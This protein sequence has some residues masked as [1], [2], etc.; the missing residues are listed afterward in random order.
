MKC[1]S[2][3]YLILFFLTVSVAHSA[4]K[5]QSLFANT[6]SES[7]I[8]AVIDNSNKFL[9]QRNKEWTDSKRCLCCHTTLPYMLARGLDMNSAEN[10]KKLKTSA[11]M[12]VEN[13]DLAPWYLHDQTG[14]NSNPTESVLNAMTLVMHDQARKT[15]LQAVTLK[16]IDR[17]FEQIGDDGKLHWLDFGLEPFESKN[18]ELWGNAFAILTIEMAQKKSK[19]KAPELKYQNLKHSL[20]SEPSKLNL[21]EKSI[22]LWAHSISKNVLTPQLARQFVAELK[23]VQ[24][25]NGSWNQA[26]ILKLGQD[27]ED[28][29]STAIALLAMAKM[30]SKTVSMDRAAEWLISKQQTGKDFGLN[31]EFTFWA[32]SSMNRKNSN[33]NNLFSVDTATSYAI[34]ALRAYLEN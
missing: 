7:E 29:Y 32:S 27:K 2:V 26:A 30:K 19:Y 20:L 6:Y 23:A 9:D 25:K 4:Q 12:K 24:N 13:P 14:R 31:S 22:L 21:N 8:S 11:A 17:I 28:V 3:V 33:L 15:E 1:V 16:S 18:A 5:C 34:L 10:F